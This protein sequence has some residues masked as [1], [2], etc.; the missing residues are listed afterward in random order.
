MP[1][2]HFKNVLR[3]E[4]QK[5]EYLLTAAIASSAAAYGCRQQTALVATT[6]S[7]NSNLLL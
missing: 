4:S 3:L 2:K 6:S 1:K 5:M 7:D